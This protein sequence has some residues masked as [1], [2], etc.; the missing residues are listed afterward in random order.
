MVDSEDRVADMQ[1]ILVYVL[2][3]FASICFRMLSGYASRRTDLGQRYLLARVA[4]PKL[5]R[6][7]RAFPGI[8]VIVSVSGK[9]MR[10]RERVAGNTPQSGVRKHLSQSRFGT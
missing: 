4:L 3:V 6:C 7:L 2:V 8:G 1:V 9:P 10:P 5:R